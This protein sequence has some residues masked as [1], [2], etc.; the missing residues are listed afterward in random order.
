MPSLLNAA[1]SPCPEADEAPLPLHLASRPPPG[2]PR[3]ALQPPA[4]PAQEGLHSG[5]LVHVHLHALPAHTFGSD[6]PEPSP[7]H[8]YPLWQLYVSWWHLVV[9]GVIRLPSVPGALTQVSCSRLSSKCLEQYQA[10][11]SS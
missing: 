9:S 1:R 5:L 2:P 10:Q 11:G 3:L 8:P 6:L 4:V 7:W